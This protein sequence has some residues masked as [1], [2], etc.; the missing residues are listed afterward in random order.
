MATYA[1]TLTCADDDELPYRRENLESWGDH[2]SQRQEALSSSCWRQHL[3]WPVAQ[4]IRI[5][6]IAAMSKYSG[7]SRGL[8]L[9]QWLI[10]RAHCLFSSFC[11]LYLCENKILGEHFWQVLML[12]VSSSI[13]K[14]GR[15]AEASFG[16]LEPS[17]LI[18]PRLRPWWP[19]YRLLDWLTSWFYRRV[20]HDTHMA[21]KYSPVLHKNSTTSKTLLNIFIC[22]SSYCDVTMNRSAWL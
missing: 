2:R 21:P 6:V 19:P 7:Y 16:W 17:S 9:Q 20:A 18:L 4:D 15:L 22:T 1:A 13:N 14:V 8:P 11:K 3:S 12:A 5:S 10:Y